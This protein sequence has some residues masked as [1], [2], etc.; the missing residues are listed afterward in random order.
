MRLNRNQ[1]D[2]KD[3]SL[4][5]VTNVIHNPTIAVL[6]QNS[7]KKCDGT[8]MSSFIICHITFFVL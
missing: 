7:V 2:R 3:F 6:L 8:S 5:C 4:G 1:E